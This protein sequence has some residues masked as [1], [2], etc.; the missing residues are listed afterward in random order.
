MDPI[1]IYS[2]DTL[3]LSNGRDQTFPHKSKKS[4]DQWPIIRPLI[5]LDELQ[6]RIGLLKVKTA[7][8]L[9]PHC[10]GCQIPTE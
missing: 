9:T 3:N 8:L 2:F 6:N 10:V 4:L 1:P 7:N 5:D